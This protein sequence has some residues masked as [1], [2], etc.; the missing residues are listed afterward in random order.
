MDESFSIRAAELAELHAERSALDEAR[1]SADELTTAL[2]RTLA[3][4]ERAHERTLE[5]LREPVVELATLIARRVISREL[6]LDP[7]IVVELASEGIQA[8]ADRRPL[9][10]RVGPGFAST[11]DRLHEGL[12]E[13]GSGIEV[14]LD[15]ELEA[16]GCIVQT[17]I[18]RV[19]E[20]IEAR[21]E[22]LLSSL[23][24]ESV[25]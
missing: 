9:R 22:M 17:D 16:W 11:L 10:V 24:R 2:V 20:S 7:R 13:H 14:V 19:D 23:D 4:L 21:L 3:E 8:L 15:E 6:A 25:P 18:A 12:A 1:R 5:Q